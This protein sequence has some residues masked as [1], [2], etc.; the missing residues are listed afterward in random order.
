MALTA[1]DKQRGPKGAGSEPAVV[2]AGAA[3]APRN[4]TPPDDEFDAEP[5]FAARRK[6]YPQKVQGTFRRIKWAVLIVTLGIYY[7][8]PFVRWDRGPNAPGQAVLIDFPNSRFYFFFI[9]IW[10]QEIYYLT[11]LLIL[12]AMAL[13]LMNAVAG[14]VW[15]GYLCPQTVWTDLFCTIERWVEGDR[16]EHMMRER[17]PWTAERIAR[18][19]LKHFLWLMVAWWTGGA[20]VLYFADAPTLVKDLATFQ[21]PFV[22]YLWIGILTATTY[23]LAGHMR[24]QVCTYM[25]PWPRIQA[26]LT[27]EHALNVTYRYDRGEPRGSI[28]K[29]AALRAQGL[30]A[31]DCVDCHQCLYVCPTGV[32]IREGANL[33]C[34]QCGLCIDA[35]DTVMAKVGRPPRL[36]AYDTDLNIKRRQEGKPSE[37]R[38]VRAR[39][40]LYA[41]LIA[42]VGVV[43]LYALATRTTESISV[44]HDRNPAFVRL[45]DGSLRNG[46]TIRIVNKQFVAR[47]FALDIV[48]LPKASYEFVGVPGS[49]DGRR[50]V[51]VGPDQTREVRVLV[52][53]PSAAL[54]HS[55]RITFRITDVATGLEAQATDYFSA[56]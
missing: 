41:A 39:T 10:P 49:A 37:I 45:S 43:M 14:R 2:E 38:I 26:A 34:I 11:G 46:Y 4:V 6:I 56:P 1:A 35:C 28:K 47:E 25:C 50:V 8:L 20:W 51:D 19:G 29:N 27:D 22:A 54:P 17:G 31:G 33:G 42:V 18:L 13:F 32:D 3:L 36:I 15:C 16:R 52:V 24:E 12:A 48:G 55:T 9:E 40:V 44:I 23:A 21:A 53:S 7:L 5:L 30:P